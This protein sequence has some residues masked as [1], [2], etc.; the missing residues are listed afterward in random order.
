MARPCLNGSGTTRPAVERVVTEVRAEIANACR[1]M[2]DKN[3]EPL[4][5]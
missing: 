1:K 5:P 4:D 3:G 2:A